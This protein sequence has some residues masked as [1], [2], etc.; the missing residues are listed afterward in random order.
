MRNYKL[1]ALIAINLFLPLLQLAI[2]IVR[3]AG[4]QPWDESKKMIKQMRNSQVYEESNAAR[5]SLDLVA[6]VT[7]KPEPRPPLRC[8]PPIFEEAPNTTGRDKL[9]KDFQDAVALKNDEKDAST[10]PK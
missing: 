8:F 4:E 7:L 6:E 10:K 5:A 9:L 3:P 2:W 1:T